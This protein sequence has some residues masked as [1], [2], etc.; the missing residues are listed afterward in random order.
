LTPPTVPTTGVHLPWAEV[1]ET[2]RHWVAGVGG[3]TPTSARDLAGGFLPG[4]TTVLT[5]PERAI[6]VKAVGTDLN[7]E[8]PDFHRREAAIS[9][10][11]PTAPQ[12]PT[13]IDVYDDGDWVAL[14][15]EAVVGRPPACPWDAGELGEA[16][17]ALE[18]L[19]QLLTPSPAASAPPATLRLAPLLGGWS[20]LASR[21]TTP[22][23]L[24]EWSGQH[25]TQ[26]AQL[27][28]DWPEA[29]VG[30]TLLHCDVRSDNMLVTDRGVVFVDWPHACVGAA[31][32]DVVAWAPSVALEG[33]PSP[34]ELL[35]MYPLARAADSDA[36]TVLVAA[37]SGFL[38]SHSLRPP[39]PGLPTLRAFQAAQG[40][41]ALSWLRRR[42][43]W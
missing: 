2:V 17:R 3:G 16:V 10:A 27:E 35:D 25:L 23:G 9:A 15:F 42:T 28:S 29:I 12:L 14:A 1:P 39:P 26:L 33:G 43:G 30:D 41:V 6:F 19:H 18:G 21:A 8:S 13:L 37:F 36:V 40:G 31:V 24:D 11:L 5:C 32:F 22:V 7:P 38:V 34:G 20:T 4:A